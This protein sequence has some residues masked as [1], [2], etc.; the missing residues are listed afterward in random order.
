MYIYIYIYIYIVYMMSQISKITILYLSCY[1]TNVM[2]LMPYA[3][4]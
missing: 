2:I 4:A 3:Y 1:H